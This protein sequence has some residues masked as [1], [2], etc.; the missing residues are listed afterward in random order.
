M[1]T[2]KTNLI[3]INVILPLLFFSYS[4]SIRKNLHYYSNFN[5][6]ELTCFNC[7]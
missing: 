5:I 3:K 7:K 2:K 1:E 6:S 4:K